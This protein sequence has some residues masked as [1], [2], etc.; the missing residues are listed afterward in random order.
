MTFEIRPERPAD[1]DGIAHVH[2]L[3]F[4][5][6]RVPELVDLIR[7]SDR[8]DPAFSLVAVDGG[9]VIGHVMLSGADL[10]RSD[11]VVQVLLLS[12]MGVSP[13]RQRQGV[14]S[15][16]VRDVLARADARAEPLVVV[17][18]V[19]SF[20]PRFGFEPAS[21]HGIEPP[22]PLPDEVFMVL[23]LTAYEPSLRGRI[24]Y[25]PAFDIVEP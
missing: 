5:D 1:R 24:V 15:A 19:P 18:G 22:F 16:L 3:A 21:H 20:Y 9:T 8:F 14:G 12:P 17:E 6:P 11:D 25:P 10:S 2:D 4:R 23:P 7:A 13:D